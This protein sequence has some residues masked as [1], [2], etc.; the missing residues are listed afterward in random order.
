MVQCQRELAQQNRTLVYCNIVQSLLLLLPSILSQSIHWGNDG[1]LVTAYSTP[2]VSQQT[3]QTYP[4]ETAPNWADAFPA[5]EANEP[6]LALHQRGPRG[7]RVWGDKR[8]FMEMM[9]SPLF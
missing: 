4:G 5:V 7:R 1:G 2:G 8:R 6:Q 9:I 3:Q